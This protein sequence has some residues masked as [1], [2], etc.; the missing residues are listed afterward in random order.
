MYS[1][2]QN[3]QGIFKFKVLVGIFSGPVPLFWTEIQGPA[4]SPLNRL[5]SS[6]ETITTAE[7]N[8]ES[9]FCSSESSAHLCWL[10][11]VTAAANRVWPEPCTCSH[12]FNALYLKD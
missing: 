9:D 2:L 6:P 10:D 3:K 1:R 12:M 7:R 8:V 11:S 5:L 4:G